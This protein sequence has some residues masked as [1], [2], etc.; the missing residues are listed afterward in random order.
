MKKSW[1]HVLYLSKTVLKRISVSNLLGTGP[2]C[3]AACA[4]LMIFLLPCRPVA[5][6]QAVHVKYG[7]VL[8]QVL[9]VDRLFD[10]KLVSNQRQR[11]VGVF[12]HAHTL[13]TLS[14]R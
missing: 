5:P 8:V 6:A 11:L 2:V 4:T 12:M 10:R 7:R 9:H 13:I 3:Q 14:P 1:Q